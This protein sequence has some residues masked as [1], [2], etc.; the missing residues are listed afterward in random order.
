MWSANLAKTHRPRRADRA[1]GRWLAGTPWPAYY[2]TSL[3]LYCSR[4]LIARAPGMASRCGLT[5][6]R[7]HISCRLFFS[8]VPRFFACGGFRVFE[9]PLV[10][11]HAHQLGGLAAEGAQLLELSGS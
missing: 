9:L 11:F 7:N 4:Y 8:A 3:L 2:G 1:P 6:R 5:R 10:F